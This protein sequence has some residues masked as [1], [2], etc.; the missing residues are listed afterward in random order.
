MDYKFE[1]E[2][3][4]AAT[5]LVYQ[6][7]RNDV[8]DSMAMGMISNNKIEGVLPFIYVQIDNETFFKYNVSAQNTLQQ[9]FSGVVTKR[10]FL[11]VLESLVNCFI[12]S[13]EYMLEISSVIL[14]PAYI[15]VNPGT[16]EASIVV[17]PVIRTETGSVENFVRTLLFSTQFDQS[18]DCSYIAALISFL[19]SNQFFSIHKFK[20][21]VQ[22]LLKEK[23]KSPV[24]KVEYKKVETAIPADIEGE[25]TAFKKAE[26]VT[27]NVSIPKSEE[28][29]GG[30]T[31]STISV[32]PAVDDQNITEIQT[33]VIPEKQ[34]KKKKLF[35][36]KKEK[37]EK[38]VM[39]EPP[40]YT[41]RTQNTVVNPEIPK[42][43][44]KKE[45]KLLFGT[46]KAAQ[47][48]KSGIAIPGIEM[49]DKV[50]S[51]QNTEI[52][53]TKKPDKS[54]SRGLIP[55]QKL[56]LQKHSVIEQDFGQTVDLR[57]FSEGTTV[58]TGTTVLMDNFHRK[59]FFIRRVQTGE[60][61]ELK[62][63][64]SKIGKD[65][66]R[67]EIC[68]Q[69]NSAVSREHAVFY[70]QGEEAFVEDIK[71]TN[72]TYVNGIK[73]QPQI[74]SASLCHG[75]KIRLGDEELEF[76]VQD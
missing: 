30:R 6:K 29:N 57:T 27:P 74:R 67:N 58:L 54:I 59:R 28:G 49:P 14:D 5:F 11:K 31:E 60:T 10:R 21:L 56:S 48:K 42:E 1:Y 13:E 16:S 61:F 19:N 47:R 52:S 55:E 46:K 66:M 76:I 2:T 62:K 44:V 8:V 4:G 71:S 39:P 50:L 45:K 24:S 22:D 43:P 51:T 75:D 69:G 32:A 18:E 70:H 64:A 26:V 33:N 65:A 17:L 15:F 37:K 40:L 36:G 41:G 72:G 34:E 23:P 68:I 12:L 20:E 25:Y 9:Y 53:E 7:G 63:D 35:F 38:R 73:L 3:Q